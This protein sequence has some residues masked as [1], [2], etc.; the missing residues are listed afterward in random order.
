[1]ERQLVAGLSPQ[2]GINV[3]LR[4]RATHQ[5]D[6]LLRSESCRGWRVSSETP[7]DL[8]LVPST[9]MGVALVSENL[10]PLPASAHM[11]H[12]DLHVGKTT[13]HILKT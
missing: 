6:G 1:M 11:W 2:E 7:D 10:S 4:G 8:A 9:R 3:L 5:G 13:V 12:R